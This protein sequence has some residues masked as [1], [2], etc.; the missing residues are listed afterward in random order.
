MR[1]TSSVALAMLAAAALGGGY[2]AD[3][4]TL[5]QS[6]PESSKDRKARWARESQKRKKDSA[7]AI[8]AALARREKREARKQADRERTARQQGRTLQANTETSQPRGQIHE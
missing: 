3:G 4:G 2:P 5:G 6:H 1:R 7:E 8:A